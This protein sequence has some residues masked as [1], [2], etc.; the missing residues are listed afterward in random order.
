MF[1]MQAIFIWNLYAIINGKIKYLPG[2][3]KRSIYI[4]ALYNTLTFS[5]IHLPNKNKTQYLSGNY[6][7][8]GVNFHE[9]HKTR[10]LNIKQSTEEWY[11]FLKVFFVKLFANYKSNIEIKIKIGNG[12]TENKK[13]KS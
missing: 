1:L 7:N 3:Q 4:Y 5:I 9:V 8:W 13:S 12:K 11:T 10:I 2:I 6:T